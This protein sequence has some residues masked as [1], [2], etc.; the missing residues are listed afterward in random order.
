MVKGGLEETK[1]KKNS[2]EFYTTD[3]VDV[4]YGPQRVKMRDGEVGVSSLERQKVHGCTKQG[5]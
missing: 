2:F 4:E 1:I 3:K 5:N